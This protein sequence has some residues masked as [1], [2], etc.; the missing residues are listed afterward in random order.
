[1]A[2]GFLRTSSDGKLLYV[3]LSLDDEVAVVDT[4]SRQVVDRIKFSKGAF[5]CWVALPG[6]H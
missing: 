6:N 1:M 4:A 3:S 5:P 2:G